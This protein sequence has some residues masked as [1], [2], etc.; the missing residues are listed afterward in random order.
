MNCSANWGDVE[1][2]AELSHSGACHYLL[3]AALDGRQPL[4]FCQL[5]L[6]D[7]RRRLLASFFVGEVSRHSKY[8]EGA[9]SFLQAKLRLPTC[10]RTSA[11]GGG[12]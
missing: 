3:D 10:G 12:L 11:G 7:V 5:G 1:Q 9:H 2:G 8:C 4:S 6:S